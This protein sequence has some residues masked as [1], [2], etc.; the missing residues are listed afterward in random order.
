M[1]T[2]SRLSPLAL[3]LAVG[4]S[5]VGTDNALLWRMNHAAVLSAAGEFEQAEEHWNAAQ[6]VFETQWDNERTHILGDALGVVVPGVKSTYY[7]KP[8]EGVMLY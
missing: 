2:V 6:S 1:K 5:T 3:L 8:H 7:A 4:C